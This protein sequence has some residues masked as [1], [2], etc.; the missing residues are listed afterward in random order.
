MSNRRKRRFR[1][2]QSDVR[3]EVDAELQFHLEMHV[4]DLMAAGRSPA[5]AREE[6]ERRFGELRRVREACI[7][8]DHRRRE[9]E[10]RRE[11]L[12]DMWQDLRFAFRSLR[13]SP[14]FTLMA[15]LCIGL[16][17]GVTGTILSA[18]H[19]ILIRPLPYERPDQLVAVYSR[20]T[21]GTERTGGVNISYP[22]YVS[23]RDQNRSL[24][25]LGMWTWSALAFSGEREAERVEAATVTANLFPLLGVQPFFGRGFLPEEEHAGRQRVVL[26]GHALW[27]RRFGGDRSIV[28]RSVNVD[29]FPYLVIGVMPPGFAFPDRGQAWTPFVVEEGL[30]EGRGNRGYAGALGRL[31]P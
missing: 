22:D 12:G 9:R 27:Q 4:R 28:G 17:V 19:A 14:G 16:G 18:V 8:I 15:V 2:F 21:R 30:Q 5:A 3:E 20:V 11:V 29:G 31:K 7:A 25:Q 6:A 10:H 24:A 23:W 26:L 13:K 1:L